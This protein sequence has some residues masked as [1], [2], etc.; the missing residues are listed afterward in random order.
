MFDVILLSLPGAALTG[1]LMA[2][3]GRA[4]TLLD[5]PQIVA[6]HLP[7]GMAKRMVL[8][9]AVKRC[10]RCMRCLPT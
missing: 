6:P 7:M 10:M 1:W 4:A 8:A 2:E 5:M 3:P 9:T